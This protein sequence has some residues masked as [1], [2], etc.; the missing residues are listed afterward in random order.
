MKPPKILKEY[1]CTVH[2][3]GKYQYRDHYDKKQ[4][5]ALLTAK[6][7]ELDNLRR[8]LEHA[9]SLLSGT[10][11]DAHPSYLELQT[12][13]E[14]MRD[15]DADFTAY[16]AYEASDWEA[17]K[18]EMTAN[19]DRL[20]AALADAKECLSS[21]ARRCTTYLSNDFDARERFLDG[22]QHDLK[23]AGL[24]DEEEDA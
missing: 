10:H 19:A 1:A 11:D 8:E 22:I 14:A 18:I 13:I 23:R 3:R 15:A 24:L 2:Y 5:D 9:Q 21:L 6:D 7:V 20:Q 12:E 4:V 17:Q 16:H